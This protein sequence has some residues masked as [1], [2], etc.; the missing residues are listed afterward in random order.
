MKTKFFQQYSSQDLRLRQVDNLDLNEDLNQQIT[1]IKTS[2]TPATSI[3][4]VEFF[5]F[6]FR[7]LFFETVR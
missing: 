4:R 3:V 7:T 5:S 2:G 1:N 6:F